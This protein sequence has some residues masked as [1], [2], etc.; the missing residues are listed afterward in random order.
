MISTIV[1]VAIGGALG[2]TARY[3]VGVGA[4][5][6]FGHGYP[7]GTLIVNIVGSFLMGAMITK[8]SQMDGVSHVMRVMLTTGFL[9]AFTTFSTF[10]LDFMA[11]WQKGDAL[12]A[13][14]YM[15][16]SVILSILALGL[17]MYLMR[18]TAA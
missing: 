16:V 15:S 18:G 6:V 14:I 2:A 3:G 10:S 13:F 5:H 1:A 17:A 7:W 12:Q 4:V 11:M 8:F 9:G